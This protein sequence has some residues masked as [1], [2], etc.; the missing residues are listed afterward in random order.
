MLPLY[1]LAVSKAA[2]GDPSGLI[3]LTIVVA[4]AVMVVTSPVAMRM[5]DRRG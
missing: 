4:Q 5:A 2:R 1:G 3:A